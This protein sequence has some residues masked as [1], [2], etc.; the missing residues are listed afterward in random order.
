[1]SLFNSKDDLENDFQRAEEE[2]ISS[3][4]DRSAK[5]KGEISFQGKTR[6][7]GVVEGNIK[8]E[9]LILSKSGSITGDVHI[10]SFA[11]HG[12]YTGNIKTK[13]MTA[14]KGCSISGTLETESLTVEPGASINGEIRAAAQG[15][16]LIEKPSENEAS[17]D[18]SEK[19]TL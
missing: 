13:V 3:V 9:H 4:I 16:R 14:K 19:V 5:I 7:D 6:V 8:G 18:S 15:L 12:I 1:M 11:C 2:A 17:T 10:A